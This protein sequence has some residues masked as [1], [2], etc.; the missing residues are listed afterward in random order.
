MPF[1]V[2]ENLREKIK[3]IPHTSGVYK[4]LDR[5]GQIIYIGKAKNLYKRVSSY[6]TKNTDRQITRMLVETIHNI[7]VITTTN[8]GEALILEN[9]LIKKHQPF[10]NIDLKDNKTY[11][12]LVLLRTKKSLSL[13]KTRNKNLLGSYFGP[14]TPVSLADYYLKALHMLYPLKK[15]NR[16]N[17]PKGFK[18][19]FYFDIGQCLDYC[20][21]EVGEEEI[22]NLFNEVKGLLS[23]RK[24]SQLIK[25]INLSIKENSEKNNFEKAKTLHEILSL[26]QVSQNQ[27][28]VEWLN[29]NNF[30]V[31]DFREI[32]GVI[33]LT[34][35]KYREGKLLNK[36]SF[37]LNNKSEK[38]AASY[39]LMHLAESLSQFL[40]EYYKQ[41]HHRVKIILSRAFNEQEILTAIK[42]S[43]KY[44]SFQG[45]DQEKKNAQPVKVEIPQR[46]DK[47]NLIKIA[48]A[49]TNYQLEL[50]KTK[51]ALE[52]VL[53]QLKE[54][55]L[56]PKIPRAIE[57]YDVANTGD[58]AIMAGLVAFKDGKKDPK[59]YRLFNMRETP[60]QDD[61]KSIE[62]TIYRRFQRLLKEKKDFPDLVI[63]DGGKGQ[64]NAALKGISR[65]VDQGGSEKSGAAILAQKIPI[66]SLAKREEIIFVPKKEHG[67]ALPHT[68]SVLRFLVSIR[69]ETHRFINTRHQLK[70]KKLSLMSELL[71]IPNFGPIKLKRV[72]HNFPSLTEI[73]KSSP[74][75]IKQLTQLSEKDIINLKKFIGG[76]V[77]SLG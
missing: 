4:M 26:I 31:M 33:A 18:P 52:K 70:R 55:L 28:S 17:F 62:E 38:S 41:P 50:L 36:E 67:I 35:L 1:S 53:K 51:P 7:D 37:K 63:I 58:Q 65:L 49:N 45:A 76:R 12:Y 19:C 10:F 27:Q 39:D 74:E 30:D 11:P 42:E 40:F 56:L 29:E 23:H 3:S 14:Y 73:K 24:Q 21:G 32:Y 72:M 22:S 13:V 68:H 34:I 2:K 69:D 8:E 47:M 25:K 5:E 48:E 77:N 15:C 61:Y 71:S 44:A 46:G 20:R 54:I 60:G 59:N 64:L 43:I 75:K 66:I 16:Q 6:F 57:S 9:N